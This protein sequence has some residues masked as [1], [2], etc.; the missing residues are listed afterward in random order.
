MSLQ[1]KS[2]SHSVSGHFPP[3]IKKSH[4]WNRLRQQFSI[5][6]H[7]LLGH[8][9]LPK[10]LYGFTLS[11]ALYVSAKLGVAD[12]LS[13][14]TKTC[15]E[16]A[17]DLSVNVN[18]LCQLMRL[19]SKTGIVSVNKKGAYKLTAL[20]SRLCSD[21]PDS[22]RGTVLSIAEIYPAW[23]NLLYSLQTNKA[24][25]DK[26]FQMSFYDYL[27]QDAE[28]N[29][30]FN[31][32]MEETTRDWILPALDMCDLSKVKTVVDV[33]GST[34]ML[35][36]MILKKYPH[37]QAILFDQAHV[38]NEAGK[39]LETAHVASRCQ[40]IG[41]DFFESIPAGGDLYIISRVLLNWDDVHALQILQ[42]CR[43]TMSPSAKLLI[44]D[45]VLPNK[46]AS[47]FE[48][49]ASLQILVLG[50]GCLM[51]TADEY[52]A[53]LSKAGFQAPQLIKT[54]GMISFIEAAVG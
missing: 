42:N 11:Q 29:T 26:T 18:G 12:H 27:Q 13:Q 17:T 40:V 35:T 1:P 3:V 48:L 53:L 22:L 28:A 44:M 24:A 43:A 45:F 31:M 7:Y 4:F 5:L 54:G 46:G 41:G 9:R 20:G 25:F 10:M 33:G 30:H 47:T 51:R 37:L 2:P 21:T 34:G 32:W 38:V 19:L 6:Y 52:Y 8:Y 14:G 50:G 39:I 16:L 15:E 49:F 36:M 23:G